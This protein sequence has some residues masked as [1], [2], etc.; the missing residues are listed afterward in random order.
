[1]DE[2]A[3]SVENAERNRRSRDRVSVGRRVARVGLALTSELFGKYG[4]IVPFID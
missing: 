1:M 3:A 4:S 2:K